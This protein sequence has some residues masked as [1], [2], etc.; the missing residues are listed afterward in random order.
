MPKRKQPSYMATSELKSL[1]R[2]LDLNTDTL[3]DFAKIHP[4]TAARWLSGEYPIDART[5]MLFRL[6]TSYGTPVSVVAALLER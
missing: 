5:T 1:C 2:K 6:M 4:R 3:A